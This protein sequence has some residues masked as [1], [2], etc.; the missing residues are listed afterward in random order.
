MVGCP[1]IFAA[2]LLSRPAEYFR[3]GSLPGGIPSTGCHTCEP[4]SVF[5]LPE[6]GVG[7]ALGAEALVDP[8]G[9]RAELVEDGVHVV[10]AALQRRDRQ[11]CAQR[12][13]GQ[14]GQLDALQSAARDGVGGP[15]WPRTTHTDI[16]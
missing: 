4:D 7:H 15:L 11:R 1:K 3:Q 5:S 13:D 2:M 12:G 6:H 14:V 10:A 8:R 16:I 9:F